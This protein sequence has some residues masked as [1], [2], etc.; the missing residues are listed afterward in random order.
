MGVQ[1]T[2]TDKTDRGVRERT[3]ELP[4][5]KDGIS[6]NHARGVWMPVILLEQGLAKVVKA[7][8]GLVPGKIRWTHDWD[9]HGSSDGSFDVAFYVDGQL[10]GKGYPVGECYADATNFDPRAEAFPVPAVERSTMLGGRYERQSVSAW[11]AQLKYALSAWRHTLRARG[12]KMGKAREHWLDEAE[13]LVGKVMIAIAGG[14]PANAIPYL[15]RGLKAFLPGE[16]ADIDRRVERL[17][18]DD[19]ISELIRSAR[20]VQRVMNTGR[21]VRATSSQRLDQAIEVVRAKHDENS[22]G[23]AVCAHGSGSA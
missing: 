21:G 20:K 18:M 19:A 16:Q 22:S 11:V 2:I 8:N 7:V 9:G 12:R 13:N 6:V 10:V 3:V 17:P 23:G 5:T 15:N 14:H 4:T 1:E